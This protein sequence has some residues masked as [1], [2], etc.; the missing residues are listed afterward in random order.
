MSSEKNLGT[1]AAEHLWRLSGRGVAGVG[2]L[3]LWVLE[4]V[5]R[6]L[7]PVQDK[8]LRR[9]YGPSR[10]GAPVAGPYGT[11]IAPLDTT[12]PMPRWLGAWR[13][14]T[15]SWIYAPVTGL[16]LTLAAIWEV[17]TNHDTLFSVPAGFA[18]AATLPLVWRREVLKPVA[19]IV[20]GAACGSLLS[21]QA[22]LVTIMIAALCALYLLA[23]QLPRH[24][25]G[26]M[27]CSSL[28]V[29]GVVYLAGTGLDSVP[30]PASVLAVIAAIG[31]GDARR[32]VAATEAE[33]RE[34]NTET[35]VRLDM[36]QKEQ[37]VMRE[38][39]RI[40]RELHDVVA[41]SVSMIAVQAETAPYTMRELSAEARDGYAEIA[42]TAREAL[43]EMRRL[44]GV[45]RSDARDGAEITPQPRLDRL[46][47]LIDQHR[48]TGGNAGL[49]IRGEEHPLSATLELS[50]FRI[51][52]EALTNVR[53]HAPGAPVQVEL[54]YHPDRLA[55]RVKNDPAH[56][57]TRVIDRRAMTAQT[58]IDGFPAVDPQAAPPP[59]GGTGGHAQQG[60]GEAAPGDPQGGHGLI[61]MQERA[62]MLGGRF[63]AGPSED[64]GFMIAAELPFR[65]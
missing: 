5:G 14:F 20:L 17:G 19:A 7:K 22:F 50:A 57:M 40:A 25:T 35:L 52:Q 21:G 4:G 49:S 61:G 48:G 13:R 32:V 3:L 30:W 43:V 26:V 9:L 28:A 63:H 58:R 45:L 41:H 2:Q 36:A 62:A 1:G 47:E 44:L 6:L 24:S 10:Q 59:P 64:G 31:L 34:Q 56:V 23:Q 8:I 42:K 18:I 11:M 53:R 39:A 54:V 29:V 60:P 46:P 55:V 27:A 37:A 16:A 38:R 33:A 51:V 12:A 65:T 15:A